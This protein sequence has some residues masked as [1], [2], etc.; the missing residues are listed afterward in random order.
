MNIINT[1][2]NIFSVT[3]LLHKNPGRRSSVV[4]SIPDINLERRMLA[5]TVYVVDKSGMPSKLILFSFITLLLHRY[6]N[7]GTMFTFCDVLASFTVRG[8]YHSSNSQSG[9]LPIVCC[10]PLFI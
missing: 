9:G 1:E 10:L 6:S 7:S 3:N 5:T 8:C 4:S 2:Q